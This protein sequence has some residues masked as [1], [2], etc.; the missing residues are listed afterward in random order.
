MFFVWFVYFL[1]L[2]KCLR[3]YKELI[4]FSAWFLVQ[5]CPT[6]APLSC[7]RELRGQRIQQAV[8]RHGA[9]AMQRKELVGKTSG[10]SHVEGSRY[11]NYCFRCFI[12]FHRLKCWKGQSLYCTLKDSATLGVRITGRKTERETQREGKKKKET[13]TVIWIQSTIGANLF[14]VMLGL[15]VLFLDGLQQGAAVECSSSKEIY[16]MDC[17]CLE[18]ER[19]WVSAAVCFDI[20]CGCSLLLA[21]WHQLG[22]AKALAHRKVIEVFRITQLIPRTRGSNIPHNSHAFRNILSFD[23]I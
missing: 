23:F 15:S 3:N 10:K 14:W 9:G 8:N 1:R 12:L 6:F 16:A 4:N 22:S 7:T 2:L 18:P 17:K 11:Q 19:L 13:T 21:T 5:G 20:L